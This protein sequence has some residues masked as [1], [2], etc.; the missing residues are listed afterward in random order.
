MLSEAKHLLAPSRS[1]AS[2]RVTR[3]LR[4]TRRFV[5]ALLRSA[6]WSCS[7][8]RGKVR[9]NRAGLSCLDS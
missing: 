4:L 8:E 6:D 7:A 9:T 5:Q 2:L 1:F 3:Q